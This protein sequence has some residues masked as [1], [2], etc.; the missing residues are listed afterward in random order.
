MTRPSGS[1]CTRPST[2]SD[3]WTNEIA[4]KVG[5]LLDRDKIVVTRIEPTPKSVIS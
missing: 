1:G 2:S 3:E 5:E 4:P